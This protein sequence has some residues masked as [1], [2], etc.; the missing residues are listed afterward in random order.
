MSLFR[1]KQFVISHAKSA[2]KVGTDGILIG[3]WVSCEKA[4]TILDVG[5]GTG[6]ITLMLAQRNLKSNIKG[7]ELDT[8]ASEEACLNINNTVWKNRISIQNISFQNFRIQTKFDLIVSNP[9]FF[10]SNHSNDRRDIARHTNCLS[11]QELIKHSVRLLSPNGILGVIIPKEAEIFFCKIAKSYHLYP[12]R[13]CYVRGNNF[14]NIK[15]VLIELS[16][17]VTN[18]KITY[19]TIEKSRHKYTEEFVN[20]CK[21]FYIDM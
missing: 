21:A 4:N 12:N 15:R 2:M 10:A 19:L 9:P 20:L 8:L 13:A 11:F 14:S 3:S 5:C 17:T 18:K 16:F 7:I 6:L 1:F